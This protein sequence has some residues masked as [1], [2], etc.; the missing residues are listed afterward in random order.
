M[1]L[2]TT[3]YIMHLRCLVT[4]LLYSPTPAVID[5]IIDQIMGIASEISDTA[6]IAW[7]P[8]KQS[9]SNVVGIDWDPAPLIVCQLDTRISP[10]LRDAL[11]VLKVQILVNDEEFHIADIVFQHSDFKR[12]LSDGSQADIINARKDFMVNLV[13]KLATVILFPRRRDLY[14]MARSKAG[15]SPIDWLPHKNSDD[16]FSNAYLKLRTQFSC[17]LPANYSAFMITVMS[18]EMQSSFAP[19]NNRFELLGV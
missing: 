14:H 10:Q 12:I 19:Y 1:L 5:Q 8:I 3:E 16:Y 18:N 9:I 11:K 6:G 7:H 15:I 17:L 13:D 2:N 4:S